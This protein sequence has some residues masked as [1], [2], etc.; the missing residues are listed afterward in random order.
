MLGA[1][2]SR[3]A[4]NRCTLRKHHPFDDECQRQVTPHH[5]AEMATA[6]FDREGAAAAVSQPWPLPL[7]F[8]H[9][10]RIVIWP[11]CRSIWWK[12][13]CWFLDFFVLIRQDG[14]Q[15]RHS[16]NSGSCRFHVFVTEVN[17]GDWSSK[18]GSHWIDIFVCFDR[19]LLSTAAVNSAFPRARPCA[20]RQRQPLSRVPQ[21]RDSWF[22]DINWHLTTSLPSIPTHLAIP[23]PPTLVLGPLLPLPLRRSFIGLFFFR[24]VGANLLCCAASSGDPEDIPGIFGSSIY[25]ESRFFQRANRSI[26]WKQLNSEEFPESL[27]S[28]EEFPESK[29]LKAINSPVINQWSTITSAYINTWFTIHYPLERSVEQLDTLDC[30]C[31]FASVVWLL[32]ISHPP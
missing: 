24:H 1:A 17:F 30:P 19:Q 13:L 10:P 28:V 29:Q 20:W 12:I 15:G 5:A 32:P 14:Q 22:L 2:S 16:L 27:L 4:V 7:K 8:P 11:C 18:S 21:L 6:R 23:L 9:W 31:A 25:E 3:N 26:N